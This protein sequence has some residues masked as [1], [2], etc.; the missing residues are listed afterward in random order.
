M[1]PGTFRR[2]SFTVLAGLILVGGALAFP[3]TSGT[4][5]ASVANQDPRGASRLWGLVEATGAQQGS[6]PSDLRYASLE[7]TPLP[8]EGA[9]GP[10][11]TL[12][13]LG[14]SFPLSDDET[15][16]VHELLERGGRVVVADDTGQAN[17]LLDD[18]PTSTRIDNASLIDLAYRRQPFFPVLFDVTPHPVTE[19]VE[20]LVAN[21]AGAVRPG[22]NA[23]SL[24][25]SSRSS[26]L[27]RDGNGTPSEGD[28]RGPHSV[29][30]VEPVGAGQLVVLSDP[31][32]LAN[33]MLDE[34]DNEQLARNLA[35]QSTQV[36]ASVVWDESHRSYRPFALVTHA[37]PAASPT[38]TLLVL[39]VLGG[40]PAAAW[41][42][43]E[44]L[45]WAYERWLIPEVDTA[46][47]IERVL[48][49]NPDWRADELRRIAGA[50]GT[51]ASGDG[52]ER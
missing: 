15:D 27:D 11:P 14:P 46:S 22:P 44:A 52:S 3:I 29:L 21:V 16:R 36:G 39:A 26:W 23:T 7:G 43:L 4:E 28:P 19:G 12:F 1:D 31:S 33:G 35:R 2:V 51:S 32:I 38:V 41:G 6:P 9:P 49:R 37:L 24:V 8:A 10:G 13:V 30:S 47:S 50:I 20:S 40:L 17:S 34:G 45:A 48:E 5:D 18:L 25:E 42:G